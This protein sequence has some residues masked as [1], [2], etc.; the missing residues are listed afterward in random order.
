[1]ELLGRTW[2]LSNGLVRD[3]AFTYLDIF[4]LS[5]DLLPEF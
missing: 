3:V 2:H 4:N 5:R 1:M